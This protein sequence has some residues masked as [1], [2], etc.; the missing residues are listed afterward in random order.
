[1][2]NNILLID[3]KH[4]QH[5]TTVHHAVILDF[6]LTHSCFNGS[7]LYRATWAEVSKM[8]RTN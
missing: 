4:V 8:S 1:M 3:V 7:N 5:W 6:Y 2:V